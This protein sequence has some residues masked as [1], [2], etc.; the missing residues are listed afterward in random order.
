M[1]RLFVV[2][3]L[4]GCVG[5]FSQ[6]VN[7]QVTGTNPQP[8]QVLATVELLCSLDTISNV[9]FGVYT[10][11]A[12]SSSAGIKVDCNGTG[13]AAVTV[14]LASANAWEMTGP[15]PSISDSLVYAVTGAN[16]YTFV[17]PNY[18]KSSNLTSGLGQDYDATLQ[19]TAAQTGRLIGSYRDDVTATLA[20]N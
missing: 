18:V 17:T 6:D 9:N 3:F 5:V 2:L 12:M 19:I 7:A 8:F 11:A 20:V 15:R 13:Q 16:G 1:K 14:T 4:V 10:G